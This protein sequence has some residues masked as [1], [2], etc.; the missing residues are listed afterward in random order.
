[1][2]VYVKILISTA[3]VVKI[4]VLSFCFLR[5]FFTQFYW[6]PVPINKYDDDNNFCLLHYCTKSHVSG[7]VLCW[8][9]TST[10]K[11]LCGVTNK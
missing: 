5:L 4:F 3:L 1:M 8:P 7:I 11:L 6:Y 10:E 2:R 9:V